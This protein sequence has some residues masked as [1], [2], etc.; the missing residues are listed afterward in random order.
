MAPRFLE[1]NS[2]LQRSHFESSDT[3]DTFPFQLGFHPKFLG[4]TKCA[5]DRFLSCADPFERPCLTEANG[6]F[7]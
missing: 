4:A 7:Q 6:L 5:T 1:P 2:K 3:D